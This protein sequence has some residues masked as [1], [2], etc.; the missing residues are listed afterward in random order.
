MAKSRN[1]VKRHRETEK[2]RKA[3]EKRERRA[4]KKET[5]VATDAQISSSDVAPG[6]H[7]LKSRFAA[8]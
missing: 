6:M 4:R 5:L 1:S 8:S 7:D 2:K 3:D